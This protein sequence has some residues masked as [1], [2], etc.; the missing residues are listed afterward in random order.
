MTLAAPAGWRNDGPD[1]WGKIPSRC[2][3]PGAISHDALD[4]A[5]EIDAFGW[6]DE[7]DA[8]GE[9]YDD[10]DLKPEPVPVPVK[11]TVPQDAPI[12]VEWPTRIV[13]PVPLT[14][15]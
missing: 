11:H 13:Q 2:D 9:W 8:L 4:E 10:A 7:D 3:C 15:R 1:A 12:S 5:D 6:D 14:R